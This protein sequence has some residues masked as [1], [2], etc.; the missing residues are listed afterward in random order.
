MWKGDGKKNQ[1]KGRMLE[2]EVSGG[3][4][5]GDEGL[6][7]N[8]SDATAAGGAREGECAVVLTFKGQYRRPSTSSAT[9]KL[10]SHSKSSTI[11]GPPALHL[12]LLCDII[13]QHFHGLKHG[14]FI[15]FWGVGVASVRLSLQFVQMS[16]NSVSSSSSASSS[17]SSFREE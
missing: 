13:G 6:S 7:D 9:R 17:S 3:G 2:G 1:F 5:V 8:S 14:Q 11:V 4:Y 12:Y 10:K 16:R 15:S